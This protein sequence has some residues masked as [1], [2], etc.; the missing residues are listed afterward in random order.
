MPSTIMSSF[1]NYLI[2]VRR[3]DDKLEVVGTAQT[4][5][6]AGEIIDT[7]SKKEDNHKGICTFVQIM[8][9]M[10]EPPLGPLVEGS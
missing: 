2:V 9:V 8:A 10:N 7:W 5:I 6:E 4:Q 1:P 3:R